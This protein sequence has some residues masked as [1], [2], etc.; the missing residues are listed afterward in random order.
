MFLKIELKYNMSITWW[1]RLSKCEK[2]SGKEQ[3]P[4][5]SVA[6]MLIDHL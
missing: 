1:Q 5:L 6:K 3:L 4:I 2:K